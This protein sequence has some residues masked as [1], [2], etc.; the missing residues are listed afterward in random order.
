MGRAVLDIKEI[1]TLQL[2]VLHAA[3][4]IHTVCLNLDI[5]NCCCQVGRRERSGGV[6]LV[7]NVP[8]IG[9]DALT[10]NL[11][12]LS[13]LIVSKTGT[14]AR[15]THG[16]TANAKRQKMTDRMPVSLVLPRSIVN[17]LGQANAAW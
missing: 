2:A 3:S 17:R 13:A 6:P 10:L 16:N 1:L 9:T 5:Q 4:G 15:S 11:I 12:E 14:W 7:A 8:A